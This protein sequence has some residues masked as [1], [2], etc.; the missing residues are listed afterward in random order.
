M[1]DSRG[2]GEDIQK[3]VCADYAIRHIDAS[4]I[5]DAHRQK[6]LWRQK[7]E[8]RL[9]NAQRQSQRMRQMDEVR[10]QDEARLAVLL[11]RGDKESEWGLEWVE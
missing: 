9:Y 11:A 1:K 6:V 8:N 3:S 5:D 4:R 10:R 2:G 7:D